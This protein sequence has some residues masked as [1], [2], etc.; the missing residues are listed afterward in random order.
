MTWTETEKQEMKRALVACLKS[1]REVRKVVLF[2]S[3]LNSAAPHD[4]DVAVFQD[5][6]EAYLPLAMK[7]RRL[8]REIADRIPLDIIPLRASGASCAL[9]PEIAAGEVLYE[10]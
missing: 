10:R 1:E 4:L 7:Y 3:F 6:A 9:S 2:G 8:T 5:S